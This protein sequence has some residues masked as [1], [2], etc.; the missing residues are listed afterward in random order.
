MHR[1]VLYPLHGG[2]A[3]QRRGQF[4]D[5]SHRLPLR[6]SATGIIRTRRGA[7]RT[8][9]ELT[10]KS[11]PAMKLIRTRS[12]YFCSR[13]PARPPPAPRKDS[14][15][16]G[17]RRVNM[18]ADPRSSSCVSNIGGPRKSIPTHEIKHSNRSHSRYRFYWRPAPP[19]GRI[20]LIHR[21]NRL[22]Q[23]EDPR[24]GVINWPL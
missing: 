4:G 3:W 24:M 21:L 19:T 16:H 8:V 20:A 18:A 15:S 14:T 12:P 9:Y 1:P 5:Q 2:Y 13:L 6:A 11:T 10:R 17:T 22:T 23:Y 7:G